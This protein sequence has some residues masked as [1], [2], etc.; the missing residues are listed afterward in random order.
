[1]VHDRPDQTKTAETGQVLHFRPRRRVGRE[2]P[3]LRIMLPEPPRDEPQPVDDLARY[4]Q[5]QDEPIDYRNR[6]LMNVIA[7]AVVVL[8]VGVGV[9]LADTIAELQKDQDCI[10]QGRVNCAPVELPPPK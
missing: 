2:P 9:W 1:M 8:L 3:R 5:E 4:E 7:L 10:L 6:M